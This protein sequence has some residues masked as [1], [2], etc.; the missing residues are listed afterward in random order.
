MKSFVVSLVIVAAVLAFGTGLQ[1]SEYRERVETIMDSDPPGKWAGQTDEWR[2]YHIER[3]RDGILVNSL[4]VVGMTFI[5]LI[6]SG[7]VWVVWKVTVAA[8]RFLRL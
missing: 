3:W 7:M 4:G 8:F 5:W 6:A 2:T 1:Y